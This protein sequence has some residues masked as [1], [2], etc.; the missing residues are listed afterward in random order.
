MLLSYSDGERSPVKRL[1]IR[2]IEAITGIRALR[3]RYARGAAMV[4]EGADVWAAALSV[5]EI[6]LELDGLPLD[7]IPCDGPLLCLAN[8]PFGVVDGIAA[9]HILKRVRSD[10]RLMAISLLEQIPEIRPWLLP[11][12]FSGTAEARDANLR[13]RAE[14][15]CRLK[16]GGAIIM[17]PAGEVASSPRLF[18]EAVESEWHPFAGRLARTAGVTVLPI[19]FHGQNS[20]MFNL[21]ARIGP[22]TRLAMF[23]RETRRKIGTTIHA[24]IGCP[25]PSSILHSYPNRRELLVAL[26]ARVLAVDGPATS[27]TLPLPLGEGRGEGGLQQQAV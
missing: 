3:R 25:I 19:Y 24:T 4:A 10:F 20:W 9:C 23:V 27:R 22:A 6:H 26:R 7:Q 1:W 2:G 16:E 8:H 5:L 14:A 17:F 21:A 13:A 11:I 12:D 15:V 18:G